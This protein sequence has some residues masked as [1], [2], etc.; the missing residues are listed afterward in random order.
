MIAYRA[1]QAGS[2]HDAIADLY[3]VAA[4]ETRAVTPV[5]QTRLQLTLAQPW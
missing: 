1:E 4:S 5:L 2:G 3:G